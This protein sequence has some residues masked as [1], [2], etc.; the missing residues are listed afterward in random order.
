MSTVAKRAVFAE[1]VTSL[2]DEDDKIVVLL[3]DI[4][5]HGF[6]E[7]FRKHPSRC[8]NIGIA[9]CAMVGIAA[10]LAMSGFYP[11]VSTITSF[12]LRRAYEFIRLDFHEQGLKGLFVGI[13]GQAEYW[14]LGP[15][16]LCPEEWKLAN[17][18]GLVQRFPSTSEV[19][20]FIELAC[21][22]RELAYLSLEE[23]GA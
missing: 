2:M 21:A 17:I 18:A 10:G 4:G 16:H 13:G 11:I 3:G 1:T 19:G 22:Q 5:I 6:R 14:K 7:A 12:L 8:L 20:P 15:T 9:E 23:T